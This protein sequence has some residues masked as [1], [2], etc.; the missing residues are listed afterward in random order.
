[1]RL[2]FGASRDFNINGRSLTVYGEAVVEEGYV[3][4]KALKIMRVDWLTATGSVL[5]LRRVVCEYLHQRANANSTCNETSCRW[6]TSS[7]M[8][9][10]TA[11]AA[12]RGADE[13]YRLQ[14]TILQFLALLYKACGE[15][16]TVPRWRL[17]DMRSKMLVILVSDQKWCQTSSCAHAAKLPWVGELASQKVVLV[18]QRHRE[19]W[20]LQ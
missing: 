16:S 14:V 3:S 4:E 5:I 19:R 20:S 10:C 12:P 6:R 15:D 18:P 9:A 2:T 1:M 7:H 17:Q 13:P 11:T 8:T